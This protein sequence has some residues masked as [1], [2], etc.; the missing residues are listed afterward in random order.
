MPW[1]SAYCGH[2]GIISDPT[3]ASVPQYGDTVFFKKCLYSM[4]CCS[5]LK[6]LKHRKDTNLLSDGG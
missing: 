3:T 2:G 4:F 1:S 5:F 6:L